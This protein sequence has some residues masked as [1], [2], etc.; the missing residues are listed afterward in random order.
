MCDQPSPGSGYVAV[1]YLAALASIGALA[2][3]LL[4]VHAEGW[5]A[6]VLWVGLFCVPVGI[7]P[8]L[9]LHAAY[10]TVYVFRE[11]TLHLRAGVL[12]GAELRYDEIATV[13]AAPFV[14][15]VLGWWIRV[16]A[17]SNRMTY[18]IVITLDSGMRYY[19]SPSDP[20]AFAEALRSRAR[21]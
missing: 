2:A 10:R 20:E 17:I 11:E 1:L 16:R 13:E 8:I 5:L 15:N 18:G 9:L 12:I 14:S 19:I 6:L 4:E 21:L 3:V 7:I